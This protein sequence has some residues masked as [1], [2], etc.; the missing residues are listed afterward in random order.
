MI[1]SNAQNRYGMSF[2]VDEIVTVNGYHPMLE[3]RKLVIKEII[4][5]ESCESGRMITLE[6]METGKPLKS[7][8]DTNWLT[9][10]IITNE[11]KIK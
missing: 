4:E 3:G 5:F 1:C 6:D 10:Q 9:K 7:Q 8:L 2:S 11:N